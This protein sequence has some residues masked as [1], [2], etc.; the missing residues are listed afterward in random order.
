MH[1]PIGGIQNLKQVEI[2]IIELKSILL[3]LSLI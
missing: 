2:F 3:K 1:Y